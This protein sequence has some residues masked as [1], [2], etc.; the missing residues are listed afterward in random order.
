[1]K[2]KLLITG[3]LGYIGSF[4]SRSFLKHNKYKPLSIDN[5]SR[6]NLFAKKFSNFKKINI[7]NSKIEN[8]LI[9]NNI[10]VVL[11][12]AAYSCVRE[13]VKKRKKYFE[14]NYKSQ[15]TFIKKLKNTK[16][17]YFI[18]SSS[19][20]IFDKNKLKT[21]PS[22]YTNYKLK[23][24]NHLKKIASPTFK[25]IVLRYPNV[26]G[27]DPEGKLGEKNKFISRIVPSFYKNLINKK[28]N[29][30]FYDFKKKEFPVRSYMHVSD[31]ANLNLKVIKNLE[32][33][34]RNLYTFNVF[35]NN[36]YSNYDV[37]KILADITCLTPRYFLKQ[38]SSKESIKPIYNIKNNIFKF[39]SFKPKYKNFKS[40]LMTNKKWFKKIY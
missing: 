1:M 32:K 18:F 10:D 19:L 7:S 24:E 34:K 37:I 13:S 30:I 12:L 35:N 28:V 38:I 27:S 25:V 11:H 14:N 31:I 3:G 33:F 6:G 29:T 16:V 20:S 9:K 8:I 22:P 2:T 4:T 39:L 17:K 40:I 21:N 5:M 23:I 36:Y 26:I 15:I